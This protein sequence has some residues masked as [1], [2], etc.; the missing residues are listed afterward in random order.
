MTEAF[1]GSSGLLHGN[2]EVLLARVNTFATYGVCHRPP[3]VVRMPRGFSAHYIA[4]RY[5]GSSLGN[6]EHNGEQAG[7]ELVG[8]GDLST[9]AIQ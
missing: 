6:C 3:R 9:S 5:L 2:T 8:S 7:H 4:S 1:L